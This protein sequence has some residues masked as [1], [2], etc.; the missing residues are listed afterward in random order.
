MAEIYNDTLSAGGNSGDLTVTAGQNY[1]LLV[2]GKTR[3]EAKK[4][5]VYE[6]IGY[7]DESNPGVIIT[8]PGTTLRLVD[9]SGA[10]NDVELNG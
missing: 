9:E 4:G 10:D 3:I 1:G 6:T 7:A 8:A 2:E 5:S